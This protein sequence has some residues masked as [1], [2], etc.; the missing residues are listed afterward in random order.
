MPVFTRKTIT[1]ADL[2]CD[3]CI[4]GSGAGGATL[5]AGLVERGLD[6]IMLEAGEYDTQKDFDMNETTAFQRRYQEKGL[7]ATEDLAIT[8]LQGRGVGGSTT[9]NW[10][11]CF[12]TPDRILDLWAHRHGVDTL[13]SELLRPHFEA[14]EKRLS[15]Q[16]WPEELINANNQTLWKGANKLGW[17][18]EPLRRNVLGCMNSGYCGMGC[19]ADAKQGMLLTY[20]PDAL[21]KGLR[22]YANTKAEKLV[23]KNGKIDHIEVSVSGSDTRFNI[24][25]KICVSSCGA[26]NGP[27]L[28]LRSEINDNG[29]VGLRTFLHPVAG[30]AAIF[31]AAVNGWYGA[32][33][34]V[35]SHEFIDRGPNKVGFF[36]EHAPTHPVLAATASSGFGVSQQRF[37]QN[38]Y[39]ASFVLALHVDGILD[40]DQGGRVTVGSNGRIYVNYPISDALKEGFQESMKRM[41][42]VSLAAGAEDTMT[43]HTVPIHVRKMDEIN[44]LDSAEY[45]ALKHGLFSAHQMGGLTMGG[46]PSSSVVNPSLQHHRITNLFVVDGSVFP[47]AL[48]VNPSES[49]YGL[50]HW[51]RDIVSQAI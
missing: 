41:I 35:S 3:V 23:E 27:A 36:L 31:P 50:A 42:E 44:Q 30:V 2:S 39:R 16:T 51:A 45:G 19:P 40:S 11:S 7:R 18:V 25:P 13:S 22:L 48:G 38:L 10:T 33:Q 8:I 32:P 47:T 37:M 29:R 43:L 34:S 14:I 20:I 12:R 1:A 46:D 26:V 5:A 6:V 9:I 15:I 17:N 24:R 49:I 4:I 21:E 28:F